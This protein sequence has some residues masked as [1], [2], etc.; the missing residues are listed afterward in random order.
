MPAPTL[1]GVPV[2]RGHGSLSST[3][4]MR[5]VAW[6]SWEGIVKV[7]SFGKRNLIRSP[8]KMP[9]KVGIDMYV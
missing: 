5:R 2:L 9:R 4:G 1:E 8:E 3:G 7:E 6:L